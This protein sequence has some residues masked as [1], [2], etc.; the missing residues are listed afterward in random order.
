MTL[1]HRGE[2]HFTQPWGLAGGKAAASSRTVVVRADGRHEVVPSKATINLDRHDRVIMWT[3]GGGGYG[4]PLER[5]AAQVLED[6]FD[7]KI[8][9]EMARDV[10][11]VVVEDGR[12]RAEETEALRNRM[13][14]KSTDRQRLDRIQA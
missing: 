8:G 10:Y 5:P 4:E 1:S 6:V 3:S 2:R 9:L 12:L 11:G 14:A 13:R 7:R